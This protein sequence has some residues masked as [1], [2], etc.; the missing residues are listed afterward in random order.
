M[1]LT[2]RQL[3]RIIREERIKILRESYRSQDKETADYIDMM[4]NRWISENPD[5]TPDETM[6]Q[7][8]QLVDSTRVR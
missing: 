7:Y 2:K 8:Y 3:R 5:A 1:K 4:M 6:H